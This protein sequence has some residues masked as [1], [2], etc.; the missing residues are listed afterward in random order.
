MTKRQLKSQVKELIKQVLNPKEIDRMV[1]RIAK[2]NEEEIAA[3]DV[4][5]YKL[6]KLITCAIAKELEAQYKPLRD[7]KTDLTKIEQF[8]SLL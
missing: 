4:Y 5:D 8:Y 3:N 1:D 6:A 7:S 2:Q